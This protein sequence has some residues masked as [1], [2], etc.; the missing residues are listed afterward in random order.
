MKLE[1][2]FSVTNKNKREIGYVK[3]VYKKRVQEKIDSY[4]DQDD[5]PDS[6]VIQHTLYSDKLEI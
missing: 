1:N 6:I 4:L 5:K 3:D 2:P